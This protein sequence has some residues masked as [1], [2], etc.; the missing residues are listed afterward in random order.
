MPNKQN[1]KRGSK[2]KSGKKKTGMAKSGLAGAFQ[3]IGISF[4][5]G[6]GLFALVSILEKISTSAAFQVDQIK[7]VG[8]EHLK[9]NE[10]SKAYK[11]V[12]GQNIFKVDIE[13]VHQRLLS[14]PRIKTATV[15]KD[16]PNRLL[17]IVEEQQPAAARF[18]SD[19]TVSIIDFEGN[20]LQSGL[21]R[22]NLRTLEITLPRL[23]HFK[24][25]AYTK[26]LSLANVLENRP[27]L[28]IDLSDPK[29]LILHFTAVAEETNE[30]KPVGLLHLGKAFFAE[31]WARF[32]TIEDDLKARGL[33]DW[34]IDLR[35]PGQVI[36]KNGALQG[37]VV[38]GRPSDTTY[39]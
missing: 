7:W 20:V 15:K 31:R 4:L 2:K 18:E 12:V 5:F 1:T 13:S 9:E 8:L 26:A 30:E 24:E 38:S 39:F 28:W 10:I 6:F 35:F 16:F 19:A 21:T 29:D 32:L 34:E 33:T 22:Q 36:V 27:G 23:I 11:T 3:I 14:H 37:P 25:A 17:I